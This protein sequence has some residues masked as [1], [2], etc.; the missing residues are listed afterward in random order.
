M[1]N[2]R[3]C[4]ECGK[5]FQYDGISKLC[6]QCRKDDDDNYKK[7]REYIYEHPKA[8]IGVVSEE[9]DVPDDTILR[10]LREGRLELSGDS[11][12]LVLDC[13]R[14][15]KAI[16]TGQYCNDCANVIEK[17]LRSGFEIPSKEKIQKTGRDQMHISK[18]KNKK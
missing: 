6:Y 13:E 10:Y 17:G 9:T 8:S 2:I 3:N 1:H 5:I 7:V 14:C 11:T 15:G 12:G 18:F 4:K 16:R